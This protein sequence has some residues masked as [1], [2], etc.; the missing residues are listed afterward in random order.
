MQI[1]YKNNNFYRNLISEKQKEELIEK[2]GNKNYIYLLNRV[3]QF[4]NR[5]VQ[6]CQQK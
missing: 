5:V 4:I 2:K 1:V 3:V 6:K